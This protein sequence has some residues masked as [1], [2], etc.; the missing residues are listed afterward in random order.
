MNNNQFRA[1]I[2]DRIEDICKK[3]KLKPIYVDETTSTRQYYIYYA[4]DMS[5]AG[6]L[7]IWTGNKE[8]HIR[9]SRNKEKPVGIANYDR[10]YRATFMELN[11]VLFALENY[12]TLLSKEV[13]YE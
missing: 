11:K 5:I 9:E 1:F 13:I 2:R 3:R 6:T 4:D 12:L 8:I 10:D 7:S